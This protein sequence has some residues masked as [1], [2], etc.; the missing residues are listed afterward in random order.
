MG[1]GFDGSQSTRRL[2]WPRRWGKATSP[3]RARSMRP[4]PR[5]PR[6]TSGIWNSRS[7]RSI[8]RWSNNIGNKTHCKRRSSFG[9]TNSERCGIPGTRTCSRRKR[10]GRSPRRNVDRRR[11]LAPRSSSTKHRPNLPCERTGSPNCTFPELHARGKTHRRADL[12]P[13]RVAAAPWHR[14]R[15]GVGS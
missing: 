8:P 6:R 11:W 10:R 9:M 3:R 4:W 7:A 5:S 12:V 14:R 1:M 15:T 2:V 13:R